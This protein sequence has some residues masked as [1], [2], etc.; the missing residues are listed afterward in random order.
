MERYVGKCWESRENFQWEGVDLSLKEPPVKQKAEPGGRAGWH[1]GNREH[2]LQG[3]ALLFPILQALNDALTMW[4]NAPN[5]SV[6]DSEWHVTK[7][8]KEIKD[9]VVENGEAW[10]PWCQKKQ[11]SKKFCKFAAQGRTENTPRALPWRSSIRSIMSGSK[12]VSMN[13]KRNLYDPPEVQIKSLV[14]PEG[15]VNV[16]AVVENGVDYTKNLARIHDSAQDM[17]G[18]IFTSSDEEKAKG[19]E[20]NDKIKGGK[21]WAANVP[22]NSDGCTGEFESFCKKTGDCLNYGHND[23]RG[24]LVFDSFSGWLVMKLS[25]VRQGVIVI[26]MHSWV[27]F[28]SDV[29]KGWTSE[30]NETPSNSR[31]LQSNSTETQ[32][33]LKPKVPDHCKDFKLEY[34]IDGKITSM[35]LDQVQKMKTQP[36]R[37]VELWHLLD[38]DDFTGPKD[39]ELALRM[40]GCGRQKIYEL[41]HVYWI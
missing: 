32:R 31:A 17:K 2:Q 34:A 1:P 39:V 14:P 10:E 5:Y 20:F 23:S 6:P 35:N 33:Q 13:P 9:K 29:T 26:K 12:T 30:N 41:T 18:V 16:W 22:Q 37:V 15:E 19:S 21:G 38:D 8:Y 27:F 25:Q 4:K 28:P 3:R 11:I 24:G 36:E 7:Y 40:T